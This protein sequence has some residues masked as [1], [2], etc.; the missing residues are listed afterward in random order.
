MLVERERISLSKKEAKNEEQKNENWWFCEVSCIGERKRRKEGIQTVIFIFNFKTTTTSAIAK[1]KD[2]T[3][4][5]V[6]QT[7][8][9]QLS[10][11]T[12]GLSRM[13]QESVNP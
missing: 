11:L 9:H 6:K 12:M 10:Y 5:I 1:N 7:Q 8:L 2:K 3:D 4:K 13:E